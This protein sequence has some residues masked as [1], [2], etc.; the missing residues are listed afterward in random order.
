[1]V[2]D[3]EPRHI[4]KA[5]EEE[6]KVRNFLVR[7]LDE[8][9]RVVDVLEMSETTRQK[10]WNQPMDVSGR[11]SSREDPRQSFIDEVEEQRGEGITLSNPSLISEKLPHFTID[12]NSSLTP[13]DKLQNPV[14]VTF[15]KSFAA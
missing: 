11:G 7:T 3:L 10:V 2:I 4:F 6:F 13:R 8:D 9:E 5:H 14:D 1:V 12:R 15:V